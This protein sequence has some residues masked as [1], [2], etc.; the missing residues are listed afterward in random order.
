VTK[1]QLGRYSTRP[2]LMEMHWCGSTP[3]SYCRRH[4]LRPHPRALPCPQRTAWHIVAKVARESL[5]LKDHIEGIDE[6]I[7][8]RFTSAGG[9]N[10][11]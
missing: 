9:K 8:Q 4:L 1:P 7:E 6:E 5:A 2:A 10:S 3:Q 11:L